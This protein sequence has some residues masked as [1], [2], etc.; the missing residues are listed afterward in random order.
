MAP[1][2]GG[3][4]PEA[5]EKVGAWR[6]NGGQP[7]IGERDFIDAGALGDHGPTASSDCTS[8]I[9]KL[10][11]SGIIVTNQRKMAQDFA[12]GQVIGSTVL[13]RFQEP[14]FFACGVPM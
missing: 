4:Y 14:V 6:I 10:S 8:Q 9:C 3:E 1:A 13:A 5:E 2:D 12:L 11:K 7:A